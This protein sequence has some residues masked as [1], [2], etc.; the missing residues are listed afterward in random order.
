MAQRQRPHLLRQIDRVAAHDRAERAAAAAKQIGPRRAVA[1]PAGALLPVYLLAGAR[2]IGAVLHRMG[3][4]L[5]LGELPVD[6]AVNQIGARLKPKDI[7]RE[8]DR[9]GFVTVERGDFQLHLT[10]PAARPP[11][12]PSPR[13]P[14][15]P[16]PPL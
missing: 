11:L 15:G 6:A 14:P 9:A 10:P 7:V 16:A 2:D 1:G 13:S 8:R 3:A 4:G 12:V 5:T